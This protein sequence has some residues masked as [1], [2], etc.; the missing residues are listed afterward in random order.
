MDDIKAKEE[1]EF[2]KKII[3]DSRKDIVY[4]GMDY[5]F[6]GLIVAIGMIINYFMEILRYR[7]MHF[8][9]I[10]VIIIAIGWTFSIFT[11]FV[12]GKKERKKTFSNKI[13]GSVWGACGIAMT[14]CGF[15]GTLTNAINHNYISPTLCT[16]VGVGYYITGVIFENKWIKY[17]SF[18]W[19]IG[20]LIMYFYPGD[21]TMLLM[22]FMMICFQVI[23]GFIF[24]IESKKQVASIQ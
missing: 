11:Y 12:K 17:F 15:I 1:L 5:I 24:Y 10:W 16:I 20:S 2:I 7:F 9:W 21:Y 22:A 18:G 13:V 6:W 3:E 23:P 4:N 8:F 19:W 14:I